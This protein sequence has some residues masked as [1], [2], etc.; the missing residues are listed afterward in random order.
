MEG[1]MSGA[2]YGFQVVGEVDEYVTSQ[3][4]RR[5]P[6]SAQGSLWNPGIRASVYLPQP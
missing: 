3:R 6:V 2:T 1:I 5:S 4:R